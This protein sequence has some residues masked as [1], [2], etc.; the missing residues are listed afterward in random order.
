MKVIIA[1]NKIKKISITKREW[2]EIGKKSNWLKISQLQSVNNNGVTFIQGQQ[3]VDPSGEYTVDSISDDGK[4]MTVTYNSG[5]FNGQTKTWDVSL[6]STHYKF[7]QRQEDRRNRMERINF[8]GDEFSWAL[9]YLASFGSITAD[10]PSDQRKW[11][12]ELYKNITGED[13]T[14]YLN[15][16]YYLTKPES[17][18]TL[19]LRIKFPRPQGNSVSL[20]KSLSDKV[21]I[22][23]GDSNM[24]IN[25]NNFIKNL[26]LM[27]FRIGKN[28]DR[29]LDI[30]SKINNP[31]EESFLKGTMGEI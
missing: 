24:E 12:E 3:Y 10:I 11:F 30:L 31:D 2:K 14:D 18:Y 9:G 21:K 16:G 27:G 26:F 8:D 7:V 15:R 17:K 28:E 20:L 4:T 23:E 22:I 1:K 6:K 19:E 13:A 5:L 25:N 29:A